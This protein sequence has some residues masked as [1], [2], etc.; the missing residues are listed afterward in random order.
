MILLET[1]AAPVPATG[2]FLWAWLMIA[3]PAA[4]AALLLL[5]G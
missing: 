3:L 5:G 4:S 1:I 2:V